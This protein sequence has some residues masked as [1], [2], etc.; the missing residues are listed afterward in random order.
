MSAHCESST[1]CPHPDESQRVLNRDGV[2]TVVCVECNTEI[3]AAEVT[4]SAQEPNV[5]QSAQPP[6][7]DDIPNR[8]GSPL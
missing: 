8:W 2:L 4:L 6:C 5:T 1:C 7:G 3:G